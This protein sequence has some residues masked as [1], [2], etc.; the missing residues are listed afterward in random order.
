M[1]WYIILLFVFIGNA[2]IACSCRP[3]ISVCE[4]IERDGDYLVF[5]GR[6]IEHRDL[7]PVPINEFN[8]VYPQVMY[9]VI[10]ELYKGFEGLTD[11]IKIFGDRGN[12]NDCTPDVYDFELGSEQIFGIDS[13]IVNRNS[14]FHLDTIDTHLTTVQH[15]ICQVNSI[16][17]RNESAFGRIAPG[18]VSYPYV[19]LFEALRSCDFESRDISELG[20]DDDEVSFYPNPTPDG[21]FRYISRN[22]YYRVLDHP[23]D[24]LDVNGKLIAS[25]EYQRQ[26]DL[27][28]NFKLPIKGT[29]F[30]RYNCNGHL[31]VKKIVYN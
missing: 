3:R 19:Y 1:R 30:I 21:R 18:V 2:I 14:P 8:T 12:T 15:N 26:Y 24:I 4:M 29:Y 23:I 5:R 31:K 11:T 17:R 13:A 22:S 25:L 10:D 27:Q 9:L 20:C 6:V 16:R 28:R 7:P